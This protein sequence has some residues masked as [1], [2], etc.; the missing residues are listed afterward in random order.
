MTSNDK[1]IDP[2][3][4]SSSQRFIVKQYKV[5]QLLF[6]HFLCNRLLKLIHNGVNS[7][8]KSQLKEKHL[9]PTYHESIT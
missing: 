9:I 1:V 8:L 3:F 2:L 4:N 7:F 5:G 6:H